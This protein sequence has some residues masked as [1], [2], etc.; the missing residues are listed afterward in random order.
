[1]VYSELREQLRLLLSVCSAFKGETCKLSG[2]CKL[3]MGLRGSLISKLTLT[4]TDQVG[5]DKQIMKYKSN[6]PLPSEPTHQHK[7][8]CSVYISLQLD[9]PA[10]QSK[11][12]V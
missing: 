1:M 8:M 6:R 9:I 10:I 7:V 2:S 11:L 3:L 4:K 5:G 12:R